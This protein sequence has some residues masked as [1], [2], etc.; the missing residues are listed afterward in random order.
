MRRARDSQRRGTV[1]VL[2]AL[3]LI[4][5]F[6]MVAFAIDLGYIVHARTRLQRAADAAALAAAE[7]LPDQ[8]DA[9]LVARATAVANHEDVHNGLALGEEGESSRPDP[10]KIAYG[11]WNRNTAT[12]TSPPPFGRSPNAVRVTLCK[13]EATGNPLHLFFARILGL[14][15]TEV[16]AS[17]TAW[18]DHGICGPFVGI[19]WLDVGGGAVTDSY[20]S[21]EG[22]Y[23][24]DL[25]YSRGSVCS[26]GHVDVSGTSIVK[27]D[28]LAG[29]TALVDVA[30]TAEVTGYVG[31]RLTPLNLPPVDTSEVAGFN[32]NGQIMPFPW[33]PL[34]PSRDF[35]LNAGETFYMPAGTFYF[36]NVLLVGNS[37]L[38]VTEP[39]K[40][41]V[42]GWFRREGG[43][44]VI[45]DTDP[46]RAESLQ[47]LSTGGDVVINSC[48]DFY[49]VIYAPQSSVILNGDADLY[50]AVVG[51][52][53]MVNGSGLAHYDES[54]DLDYLEV[55]PRTMLVD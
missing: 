13:S 39:T 45:N 46:P 48:N 42:T 6:A 31:I 11:F 9:T 43:A 8:Q 49:G 23:N 28:A 52:T 55:P 16:S 29:E 21:V 10:F 30:G 51:R 38:I 41:Y 17:A 54:L 20:D 53:L 33:G 25:A 2:A 36:R 50:G 44:V 5:L 15:Q 34:L 27:G 7:K 4:A 22:A 32:D 40:I 35:T 24:L 37:Q 19:E 3:L 1:V 47:I 14:P 18:S 12:F 26:D